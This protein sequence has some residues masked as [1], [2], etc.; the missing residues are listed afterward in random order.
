MS[1]LFY[2]IFAK[3]NN[4]IN[5]S[6][7]N[8]SIY[9]NQIRVDLDKNTKI[10]K[11][12]F[13]SRLT[14]IG[15]INHNLIN[16][17]E[18]NKHNLLFLINTNTPDN[19]CHVCLPRMSWYNLK[20]ENNKWNIKDKVLCIEPDYGSWGSFPTPEMVFIGKDKIAF[21]YVSSYGGQ[22]QFETHL[23]LVEYVDANFKFKSILSLD[24]GFSDAGYYPEGEEHNNWEGNILIIKKDKSYYDILISKKGKKDKKEYE[25]NQMYMYQKGRYILD[26]N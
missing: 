26:K 16:V 7:E 6:L 1:I 3:E 23:D 12:S 11:K 10:F 15:E 8:Y 5:I 19:N 24:Y 17:Y 9:E 21:K 22:G 25:E 14:N 20:F 4:D 18:I 13:Q 2:F